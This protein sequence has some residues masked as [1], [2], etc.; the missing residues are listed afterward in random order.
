M[1]GE[2][3]GGGITYGMSA[4]EGGGA[5]TPEIIRRVGD[6]A[7]AS[8]G[9]SSGDTRGGAAVSGGGFGSGAW[10]RWRRRRR[11]TASAGSVSPD[12]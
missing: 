9:E 11:R 10:L 1:G 12:A 6:R 5:R 8:S 3:R 2:R 4:G 7:L